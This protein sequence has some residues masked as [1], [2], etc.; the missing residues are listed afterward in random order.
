[1]NDALRTAVVPSVAFLAGSVPFSNMVAQITADTDLRDVETGTV[2]GTALYRV[3]GLGPLVVAVICD[4]GKGA[5]GPFLAR[6]RPT[7]AAV[8]VGFAVAGHNWSPF[9]GGAGGRGISPAMGG[10]SLVAWPGSL[11]LVAGLAVGRLAGQTG[12]GAFFSH[13]ALVPVLRATHGRVGT[14]AGAVTVAAL[15]A[16][17]LAGNRPPRNQALHVYLSRLL[18]DSD[19]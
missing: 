6:D 9:L 17:R 3:A 15:W 19:A 18:F 12:L 13:A 2:S 16:K 5:V 11:V 1:M 4:I 7:L 14:I 8:S 10:L